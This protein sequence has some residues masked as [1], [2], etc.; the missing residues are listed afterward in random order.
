MTTFLALYR[1]RTPGDAQMVAVTCDT[2][3][4][5]RFAEELLQQPEKP[6]PDPVRNALRAGERRALQLVTTEAR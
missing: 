5:T 3:I 1:G 2:E 4:V 6:E